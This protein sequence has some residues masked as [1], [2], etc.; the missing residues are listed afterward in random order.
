[1][2]WQLSP[3]AVL[4]IHVPVF[5]VISRQEAASRSQQDRGSLAVSKSTEKEI[6]AK[7]TQL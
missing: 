7:I 4:S 1:M 6:D 5:L 3:I 2:G